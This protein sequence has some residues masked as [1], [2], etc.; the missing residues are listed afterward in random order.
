VTQLTDR[1]REL[2]ILTV[3]AHYRSEFEWSAHEPL[4]RAAGLDDEI[5]TAVR[6][7]RRPVQLL[8][9]EDLMWSAVR[10]MLVS[11]DLD[12]EE[13]ERLETSIGQVAVVELI[14]LVGYYQTL[15]L[16]LRTLRVPVPATMEMMFSD[17]PESGGEE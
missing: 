8:E 7:G 9:A 4:A 3:A 10:S 5:L 11:G 17:W 14:I 6:S 13:Y 2:A 16:L 1:A 12:D 15:A